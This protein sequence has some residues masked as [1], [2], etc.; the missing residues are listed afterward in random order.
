M[1]LPATP[2][3]DARAPLPRAWPPP[4]AASTAEVL[5][6][7]RAHDRHGDA[8]HVLAAVAFAALCG[9][10]QAPSAIGFAILI[11]VAVVR[12]AVHP[13]L[14]TP[15]LR[16]TPF[17]LGLAWVSWSA[18]SVLWS[19]LGSE[20]LGDLSPQRALLA[21][22]ALFPVIDRARLFAWTLLLSASLNAGV[23][24]AQRVGWVEPPNGPTW[25]PSGIVALP[26]VAAING[27]IALL[28]A[29]GLAVHARAAARCTLVALAALCAAGIVITSSRHPALSLVVALLLEGAILLA[30]GHVRL[31]TVG[32]AAA[33][34]VLLGGSALALV[35]GDFLRYLGDLQ[36]DAAASAR[37]EVGFSS[38]HLRFFWWRVAAEQWLAH[39]LAGGGLG[40]FPAH[41]ASHADTAG[42]IAE[43][44]I[45]RTEVLQ[46]HPHSSYL[47]ALAET[48]L[49]GFALLAGL[50]WSCVRR[51]LRA[52]AR[53]PVA[54]AA[55][56]ALLFVAL[57][58]AGECVELMNVAYGPA[59]V[60]AAIAALPPAEEAR[61]RV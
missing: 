36:R 26:S 40:S 53:D 11:S 17:W 30:A 47:R 13:L 48:G 60:V 6:A 10:D 16:W 23:Q 54:G 12:F 27:G 41:L 1:T 34:L 50:L 35:G 20:A 29:L 9:L 25:R 42:F 32:V 3:R 39:P 5:R 46:R 4:S 55:T 59:V 24:V 57:A 43:S 7:V 19:P 56:A 44:G 21:A 22:V 52:A 45:D 61:P 51:G 18:L 49:V 38:I 8:L 58:T 2:W 33:V 14:L 15:L 31:R 28:L 37:G